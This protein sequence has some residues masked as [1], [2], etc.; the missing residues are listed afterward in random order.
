[1]G[2]RFVAPCSA[3]YASTATR[4]AGTPRHVL[5]LLPL[6]GDR[7]LCRRRDYCRLRLV[8]HVLLGRSSDLVVPARKRTHTEGPLHHDACKR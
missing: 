5:A 6:Y 7:Y 1:M 3:D 2:L 8:V 4:F